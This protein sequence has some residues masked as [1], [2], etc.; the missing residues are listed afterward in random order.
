[1]KLWSNIQK[2]LHLWRLRLLIWWWRASY[3][4]FSR[5][6]REAES[7][8]SYFDF[9]KKLSETTK[10]AALEESARSPSAETRYRLEFQ[11]QSYRSFKPGIDR[12]NSLLPP[13]SF[14]VVELGKWGLAEYHE[15][16]HIHVGESTGPEGKF[17]FQMLLN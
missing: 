5:S 7:F 10:Q 8:L 6:L 14:F 13:E 9:D 1:M 16:K 12:L 11:L 17:Y 4:D 3:V 2:T 15:M